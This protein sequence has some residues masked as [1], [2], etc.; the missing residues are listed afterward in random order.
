MYSNR[1]RIMLA[2]GAAVGAL[3]WGLRNADAQTASSPAAATDQA[4]TRAGKPVPDPAGV[5]TT[6]PS[7]NRTTQNP[8]TQNQVA[9]NDG[10]SV[11]SSF[12]NSAATQ[13]SQS[14]AAAETVNVFGQGSTRQLTSVTSKTLQE[15][16]PGTSALKVLS[17]L[18]G[19]NYQSAD[20]FGAYEWSS[21]LYIRGF[22]QSQLGFTLDDIP[23]GDQQFD[24]YNGLSITRAITT[25]NIARADVSQGAGSLDIASTSNLGGAIQFTSIDPPDRLGGLYEQT[26]GSDATYREFL[27][28]DSGVLNP[29][30]TKFYVSYARVDLDKWKGAGGNDSD[31]VN[32]KLVQPI[33]ASG[34]LKVYFDYSRIRQFDYQDESLDY[35]RTL[36]YGLDNY[37]P[38]YAAAYHAAQGIYTHNE[39]LSNDPED[40]SYYAGTA[41]RQDFLSAA[42]YQTTLA[43]EIDWKSTIYGHGDSGRSTWTTPY[44][45]SPNGAPLSV[46]S[47]NPTIERYGFLSSL[48]WTHGRNTVEGGLWYENDQFT[49]ARYF[50]E[51]PLLTPG[52]TFDPSTSFGPPFAEPWG[53]VFNTIT[54]QTHLQDTFRLTPTLTLRAGFRSLLIHTGSKVT[55]QDP[56]YN[57]GNQVGSGTLDANDA[58][59]PQFSGNWRF[60]PHNELFADI[61]NNMRGFPEN[62][63]S[64][65][66]S[67]SPW[68]ANETA[69]RSIQQNL[70]PEKDWV[71]EAG[72]RLTTRRV[73]GLLSYYHVDF[74]NRLQ[75]ISTG[76]IIDPVTSVQNVG[77]VTSNGIEASATIYPIRHLAFYNSISFN[78]ST[79][80][81]DVVTSSGIE[82]I[83]GKEIPN[84]PSLMYKT[85]LAY[86]W[87]PYDAHIDGNYLSHRYLSYLNDT[88]VPNY[89]IADLGARYTLGNHGP[90]HAV[91]FSF[92]IYNLFNAKYIATMGE[93]GN[94]FSGDYQSFLVGA[95]RQFFGTVTV[96]F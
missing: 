64:T 28:L 21:S 57:G 96:G 9:Q 77:G 51:A 24:N 55:E 18:P 29:T 15:A 36:G 34:T 52:V 90:L 74:S 22:S 16:A 25:D 87:G 5:T 72:Y 71:Y 2:T 10:A 49:Q 53:Y 8:G 20:P 30:G 47:M 89:F 26:F 44:T 65:N 93:E 95:P 82:A 46:R 58:F 45:P 35:L 11:L 70:K 61:S 39:T 60:L 14:A 1:L 62:G 13:P 41:V 81:N 76:P 33:G 79:Y 50:S 94:P 42:S 27:R 38:D 17:Q 7:R 56:A 59:L 23:L 63:Y 73:V 68:S 3:A 80:D 69:F 91:T 6:H 75:T 92:N 12:P 85:S 4:S 32:A 78:R 84:Y 67:N 37:Y 54:V 88:S 86:T 40:A 43:P 31:Q 83:K 48:E 66:S 19:V